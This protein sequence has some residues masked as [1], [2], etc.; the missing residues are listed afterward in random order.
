MPATRTMQ[1]PI[2]KREPGGRLFG[3]SHRVCHKR[4][5]AVL[6]LSKRHALL[7]HHTSSSKLHHGD[8]NQK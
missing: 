8:E 7:N 1:L 2:G 3:G 4:H 6:T 5:Y